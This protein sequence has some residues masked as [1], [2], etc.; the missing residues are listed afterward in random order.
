MNRKGK[1][2]YESRGSGSNRFRRYTL[3]EALRLALRYVDSY[4]VNGCTAAQ[5]SDWVA[6]RITAREA[7]G[8]EA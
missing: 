2:I 7:S 1:M 5:A 3:D 6:A 4:V 8:E